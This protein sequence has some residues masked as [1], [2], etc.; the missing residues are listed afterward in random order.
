MTWFIYSLM[1]SVL[2][3]LNYSLGEKIIKNVGISTLLFFDCIISV[4]FASVYI[5]Y[6]SSIKQ[7]LLSIT[8]KEIVIICITV[9]CN[10][11]GSLLLCISI[12]EKNATMAGM[13]EISYPFFTA[14]FT[15]LIFS[16]NQLSMKSLFGG[17]LIMLGTY[18]IWK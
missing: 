7:E 2:W 10:I 6:S 18:V 4:L 9:A 15:Y 3:G 1:C 8:S 12:K 11:L 5:Y 14:I 17:L 13:I 16:E